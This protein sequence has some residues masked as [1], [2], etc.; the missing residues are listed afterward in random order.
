MGQ[1]M[2]EGGVLVL[3]ESGAGHGRGLFLTR[4]VEGGEVVLEELP[5][6][7]SVTE[8]AKARTCSEC[9]AMTEAEELPFKCSACGEAW[10]C[11]RACMSAA[12][13]RAGWEIE[14]A[15]LSRLRRLKGL[16]SEEEDLLLSK[17]DL[18][19][20]RLLIKAGVVK[21]TRAADFERLI[22]T[23]RFPWSLPLEP[24]A[25][26]HE[27]ARRK[28]RKKRDDCAGGGKSAPKDEEPPRIQES[29][30]DREQVQRL[31]V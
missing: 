11:T 20:A 31:E 5:T 27:E 12:E 25:C 16:V 26:L 18:T 14:C 22:N 9:F 23:L 30:E 7:I 2:G 1:V 28:S 10:Y 8:D 19:E 24:E 17:E 4:D 3:R 13:A 15:A 29:R 6:I 21:A